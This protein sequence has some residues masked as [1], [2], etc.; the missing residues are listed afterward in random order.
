MSA[1]D[2]REHLVELLKREG[3]IQ[4]VAVEKAF[5]EVPRENFVPPKLRDLAYH[6]TPLSIGEGQTISA[7][8]MVAIMVEGLDIQQGQTILEIGAGSGY[9][10]AVVAQLLGVKGHV[11]TVERH[12]SLAEMARKNLKQTGIENVT[13]EIGDGSQGF[14]RYAPYD[15]IYVT[16]AAPDIPQPLIDQ[17]KDPGK[18]MIPVGRGLSELVLLEKNKENITKR[19]LGGCAFV[20]LIGDKGFLR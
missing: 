5:L 17:L 18:L 4:S 9:H 8:H 10:A 19:Y 12:A 20:P 2:N 13:V 1:K 14:P 3:R 15:R 11:Y 6:D 16:C 7:P